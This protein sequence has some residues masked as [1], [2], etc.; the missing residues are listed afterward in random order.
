[1]SADS[2]RAEKMMM[3]VRVRKAKSETRPRCGS[4]QEGEI[5][6]RL[7]VVLSSPLEAK[8]G[9]SLAPVRRP[10]EALRRSRIW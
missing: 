5:W 9:V 1:M 6:R 7:K 10:S 8:G 2:D 4:R 3:M